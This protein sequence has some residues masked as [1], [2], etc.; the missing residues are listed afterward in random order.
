[1]NP[2]HYPTVGTFRNDTKAEMRLYLEM[3]PEEVVLAP[4]HSVELFARPTPDLLPLTVGLVDGGLQI[5]AHKVFDPD[6]HILFNGKLIRPGNPT[7]LSEH[8]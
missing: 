8:K 4:G 2:S 5:H 1:M 3:I 7:V 6:W